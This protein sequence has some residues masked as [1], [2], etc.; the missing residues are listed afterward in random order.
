MEQVVQSVA[1]DAD[2]TVVLRQRH[3]LHM[4]A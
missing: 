4:Q 1:T 2:I 3:C